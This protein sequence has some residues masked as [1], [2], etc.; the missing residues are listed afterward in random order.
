[1]GDAWQRRGVGARL[2]DK[3][4]DVARR[5]GIPRVV[6]YTFATNEAMKGL[7]RKTGFKVRTDPEDASVAILEI[8]LQGG[9]SG[10]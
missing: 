2:L 3:L 8:E 4:V 9:Q 7:A 5:A 6:G 10:A 1:V